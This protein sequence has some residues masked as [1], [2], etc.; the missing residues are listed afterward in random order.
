[1]AGQYHRDV[2]APLAPVS[3]SDFLAMAPHDMYFE[4]LEVRAF[5]VCA[6]RA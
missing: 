5:P 4:D 1:L 6:R 2:L 3:A